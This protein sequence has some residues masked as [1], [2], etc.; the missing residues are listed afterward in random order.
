MARGAAPIDGELV[1]L[2][3]PGGATASASNSAHVF[4]RHTG[5]ESEVITRS[6]HV[7]IFDAD[8]RRAFDSSDEPIAVQAVFAHPSNPRATVVV[9]PPAEIRKNK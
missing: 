4:A 2:H 9:L 6:G 8:R 5:D 1:M 3:M 7:Y